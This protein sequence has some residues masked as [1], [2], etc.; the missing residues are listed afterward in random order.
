MFIFSVKYI[1]QLLPPTSWFLLLSH[2]QP[3]W[4]KQT[5]LPPSAAN[6]KNREI[7]TKQNLVVKPFPPPTLMI[8]LCGLV[9]QCLNWM[10]AKQQPTPMRHSLPVMEGQRTKC[11]VMICS[12]PSTGVVNVERTTPQVATYRVTSRPTVLL[13]PTQLKSAM[14]V[15]KCMWA[16]QHYPCTY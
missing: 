5:N 4:S 16:C 15:V 10:E 9:E 8:I 7:E 1:P 12:S 14:C 11:L 6:S 13:T 2:T 3:K